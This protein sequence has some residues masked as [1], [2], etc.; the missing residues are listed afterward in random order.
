MSVSKVGHRPALAPYAPGPPSGSAFA[1]QTING[2]LES[3]SSPFLPIGAAATVAG[4]RGFESLAISPNGKCLDGPLVGATVQDTNP[5]R[6][7]MVEFSIEDA[8]FTDNVWQYR[9][10]PKSQARS[11][12]ASWPTCGH[13]TSTAWW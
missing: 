7:D 6:R 9:T 3:P 12:A 8:A 5:D 11:S 1:G 2:F 13:S 4:S 10:Q